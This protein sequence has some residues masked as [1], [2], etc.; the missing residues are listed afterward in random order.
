MIHSVQ[1]TEGGQWFIVFRDG[2]TALTTYADTAIEGPVNVDGTID[3][4]QEEW[5]EID[6]NDREAVGTLHVLR[7][8]VA[9]AET[10]E[11]VIRS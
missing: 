5:H 10:I 9:I 1:R 3:I 6:F 7:A 4:D 2:G 11:V 8:F